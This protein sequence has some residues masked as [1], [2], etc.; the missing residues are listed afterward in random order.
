MKVTT[1][2][3]QPRVVKYMIWTMDDRIGIVLGDPFIKHVT[4][5]SFYKTCDI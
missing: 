5:I 2:V 3:P 1:S 4:Y